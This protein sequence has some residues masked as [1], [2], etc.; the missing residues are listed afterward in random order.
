MTQ[1]KICGLTNREDAAAA[2]AMGADYLGFVLY[3]KS[4]RGI[5]PSTLAAILA[6]LDGPVKAIAVF[7]NT[8]RA[9]VE[10]VA[11]DCGLHAV[12]IHGDEA[13]AEFTDMPLPVW[14]AVRLDA[15]GAHPSPH[16]WNAARYVV[17]AAPTG[18]YGGA[19]IRADPA[20]AARFAAAHP[21]MLAGGLTADNVAGAIRTVQPL[22]VDVTSGI[23][24]APGR[25][26]HTRM[27]RFIAAAR[28]A[29]AT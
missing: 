1:V 18:I 20:A 13:A 7:V 21:A 19:G 5:T 28:S 15:D 16:A 24:A 4:P 14:R 2:L 25:K 17:D 11:A 9:E 23:E 3:P 27:Q 29:D 22:G 6:A 26:D 12:Q 8:P 10:Q